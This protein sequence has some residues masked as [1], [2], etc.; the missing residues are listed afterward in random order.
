VS[1]F[2]DVEEHRTLYV[3]KGRNHHLLQGFSADLQE[4]NASPEQIKQVSCDMSPAFIKG[5]LENL[6]E[7]S[8]VF[9]RFH[10]VKIVNEAVDKVSKEGVRDNQLLKGSKYIF[11]PKPENLTDRQ[12]TQLDGIRLSGLNLNEGFP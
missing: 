5:E 4:H 8:I 12:L 9:D 10:S 11:L 3:A 7:A 2:V 6:P 1:L